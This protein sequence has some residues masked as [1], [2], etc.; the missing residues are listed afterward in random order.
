MGEL[1]GWAVAAAILIF[2]DAT[3]HYRDLSKLV[4][5]TNLSGLGDNGETPHETLRR[6]MGNDEK[7]CKYFDTIYRSGEY[8]INQSR[9]EELCRKS[10]VRNALT[11]LMMP[12]LDEY[13]DAV[14]RLLNADY[15]Q[16]DELTRCR[17]QISRIEE[18]VERLTAARVH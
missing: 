13:R 18:L 17:Q 14:I 3:I 15:L 1:P 12:K 9:V 11:S 2:R 4:I 8:G 6:E 7:T 5:K 10:D 16:R